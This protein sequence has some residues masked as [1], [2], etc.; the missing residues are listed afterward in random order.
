[1]LHTVSLKENAVFRRLYHRGSSAG[2]RYLVLYCRRNGTDRSRLGFTVS[3]KLGHAVVRNRV[4]RRLRE[5]YR[6][7]ESELRPG[8]DLVVV[9]RSA[10]VEAEFAL[11]ERNF[12]YLCQKL[13]L[14]V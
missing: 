8:Y 14:T 9:A 1:M 11:L 12:R 3:T 6:S 13:E 2:S 4:R 5:I 7:V 10:A